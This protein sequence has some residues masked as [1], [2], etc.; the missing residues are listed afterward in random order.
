MFSK[1]PISFFAFISAM[2]LLPNS[3]F[4]QELDKN[5]PIT[6]GVDTVRA[7]ADHYRL[8]T[9]FSEYGNSKVL[10]VNKGGLKIIFTFL[11]CEDETALTD[12]NGME[13]RSLWAFP[14]NASQTEVLEIFK[15]LLDFNASFLAG[16]AGIVTDRQVF[17]SRYVI[18]DY[19]TTQGNVDLE[20]AVFAQLSSKFIERV[21]KN[22]K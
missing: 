10:V 11:G 9:S 4:A 7:I 1:I 8:Q 13:M 5:K 21:L 3:A 17:L 20:I 16:K 6:L 2:V 14:K 18:A 22:E 15:R 19:G 12:C